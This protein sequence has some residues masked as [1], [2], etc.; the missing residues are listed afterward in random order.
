MRFSIARIFMIFTTIKPL[1]TLGLKYKLVT[2][3]Y[4]EARHHLISDAHA[5]RVRQELMRAKIWNFYP[6]AEH[7]RKKLMRMGIH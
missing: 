3:T 2:L 4:G 7:T 1:V 5:K 6:Y